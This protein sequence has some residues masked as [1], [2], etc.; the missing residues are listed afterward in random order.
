MARPLAVV[1]ITYYLALLAANTVRGPASA[2]MCA[3][4]FL[5]FV[6]ALCFRS[7]RSR[8]GLMAALL[9][10]GA[11]FC[12]YACYDFAVVRPQE[13]MAG[14]KLMVTG[15]I[16]EET[17]SG[18]GAVRTTLEV[19]S[20]LAKGTR[21]RLWITDPECAAGKG[22]C[23][24][25]P[26]RLSL[27]ESWGRGPL[28]THRSGGIILQAF[29]TDYKGVRVEPAGKEDFFSALHGAA[30]DR[31]YTALGGDAGALTAGICFGDT[32]RLSGEAEDHL[33]AAGLSH[34]TA[35]SGLHMSVVAGAAFALMRRLRIPQRMAAGLN[36]GVVLLFMGITLFPVSAM[37]AGIMHIV[38]LSGIA[39]SR[40]ADGLNSLGLAVL[41]LVL[42][43]PYAACDTGLLLSFAATL[44]LL[45]VYPWM[46]RTAWMRRA[47]NIRPVRGIASSLAVSLSV[48]ACTMPVMGLCFGRLSL[49]SPVSNL[50]AVPAAA[51]L[52]PTGC[53]G[54]LLSCIPVVA[55][56]A[57]GL[58]FLAGGLARF[59]LWIAQGMERVPFSLLS[60]REGYILLWMTALVPLLY[61]G[62]RLLRRKGVR[63]A[64]ALAAILL[65]SGML[66]NGIFT[67]GVTTVTVLESG[68]GIALL[69]ERDGHSGLVVDGEET[70]TLRRVSSA[71]GQRGIDRLDFVLFPHT[72]ARCIRGVGRLEPKKIELV[73]APEEGT[74]AYELD[75]FIPPA[76][77]LDWPADS[78]VEF[79][80]D[81]RL[82]RGPEGWLRLWLGET[83]LLLCPDGG[84]AACLEEDWK[85]ADGVIFYHKPPDNAGLLQTAQGVWSCS[86]ATLAREEEGLPWRRYPI[87]TTAEAGDTVWMTRGVG[88]IAPPV[89]N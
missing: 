22:D 42:F 64:A 13:A 86:G 17:A 47:E 49:L 11:A 26:V 77:R 9:T 36:I 55:P 6:L 60:V 38:L 51:A 78:D 85:R 65:F 59:L 45:T 79:W 57:Q 72:D 68:D 58:F 28:P 15:R 62:W 29:V 53:L 54:A 1:G 41:L 10:A 50:L 18:S 16:T 7:V 2:V 87:R 66:V 63:L 73:A 39:A 30:L 80:N 23:L 89:W 27:T 67:R 19:E 31:V 74:Y 21:L 25:A 48:L 43:R 4:L 20:G 37:R 32:T 24:T 88:D 83:R 46:K 75:S 70:K 69:L 56:M 84:N 34:L 35:V 3:L 8:A 44:G 82:E 5:F 12:V 40:R 76:K 33:A 14:E 61:L 71:L 81:C 52:L